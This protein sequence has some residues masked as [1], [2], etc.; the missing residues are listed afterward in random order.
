MNDMTND[1]ALMSRYDASSFAAFKESVLEVSKEVVKDPFHNVEDIS[2]VPAI[3]S[4]QM[5]VL[6][7]IYRHDPKSIPK[8]KYDLIIEKIKQYNPDLL[9][10]EY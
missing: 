1:V 10:N 3:V 7:D 8:D 2:I 5:E 6:C 4:P 9:D